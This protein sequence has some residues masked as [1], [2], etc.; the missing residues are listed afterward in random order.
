MKPFTRLRRRTPRTEPG[1]ALSS[2]RS[3]SPTPHGS[4]P[5]AELFA[6]S[7]D[8]GGFGIDRVSES[9]VMVRHNGVAWACAAPAGA[10][11]GLD[12]RAQGVDAFGRLRGLLGGVSMRMDQ[13]VR[14][15]LYQ[16]GIVSDEGPRQRYRE[17]NRARAESFAGT[18]FL[19]DR[20]PPGHPTAVY[21]ASTG[22]GTEGRGLDLGAWAL[23]TN[24][25]DVLTVPLENPRQTAACCYP[26][27]YSPQA[28][29]FARG[30]AVACGRDAMLFISGT[31]SITNAETRHADDA[32]AQ[33]RETLDNIAAL[34]SE[35]NLTRHG[36][37]GSGVALGG[38]A[39]AR[40][41]IKRREDYP[42]V[43]AIC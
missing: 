29:L 5:A 43:R 21:P 19:R 38:I 35:Q 33:T 42:R 18:D 24:R 14:I 10:S 13:V 26:A 17:L 20:L 22:I 34:I 27:S 28:P 37:P 11:D 4:A 39:L 36:L 8:A 15:W 2:R 23:A 30:M 25:P 6:H 7:A 41:Y 32:A 9:L 40:V 1:T 12:A 31:A 3:L 16:G